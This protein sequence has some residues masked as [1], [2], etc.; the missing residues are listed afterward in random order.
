MHCIRTEELSAV[1]A[2][3]CKVVYCTGKET[4][5]MGTEMPCRAMAKRHVV[6]HGKRG[7]WLGVGIA[8]RLIVERRLCREAHCGGK[9]VSRGALLSV[10]K[11]AHRIGT[12]VFC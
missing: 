9:D 12:E 4:L 3:I 5:S 6:E 10:G 1:K 8:T 11:E 7:A 2:K